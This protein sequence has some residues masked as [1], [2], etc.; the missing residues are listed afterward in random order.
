MTF[1]ADENVQ[2][3]GEQINQVSDLI[4][5]VDKNGIEEKRNVF[6]AMKFPYSKTGLRMVFSGR[7]AAE[8]SV[9]WVFP[10]KGPKTL[11]AGTRHI[12]Q[13]LPQG[14]VSSYQLLAGKRVFEGSHP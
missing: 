2:G 11:I 4:F 13:K 8:K 14:K 3:K 6:E 1:N 10:N 5:P 7:F 9:N 12:Y